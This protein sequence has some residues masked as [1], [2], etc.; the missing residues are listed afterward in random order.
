MAVRSTLLPVEEEPC[1]ASHTCGHH[2]KIAPCRSV[3]EEGELPGLLSNV[4][5]SLSKITV[6]RKFTQHVSQEKRF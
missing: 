1:R 4:D 2:I 3:A 6:V 5:K